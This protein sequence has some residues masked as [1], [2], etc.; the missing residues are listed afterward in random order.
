MTPWN[1]AF[2]LELRSF[3]D[4]LCDVPPMLA[5]AS[6]LNPATLNA[7]LDDPLFGVINC[8]DASC[9]HSL[10]SSTISLSELTRWRSAVRARTGLPS[11]S[12]NLL[13]DNRYLVARLV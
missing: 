2:T 1:G 3:C 8:F 9:T 12:L 6:A 7:I 13:S 4:V 11:I 5:R 10:S